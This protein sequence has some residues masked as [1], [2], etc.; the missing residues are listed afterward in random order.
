MNEIPEFWR[1]EVYHPL[2]VHF[3]IVLL[4]MA[5]LFKL[6]GL[7]SSKITWEQGGRFLLILGVIG[8]WIS[9][10][11]GDLADGI[12]SRELCD[13]TMLKD[14]ENFAFITAWIFSAALVIEL[15]ISYIDLFK[16]KM[17]SLIL[18][19]VLL[20]GSGTLAYVGHLGAELVYQQAA[21]VYVPSE[22]CTEFN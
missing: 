2:S 3:P 6:I 19:L 1:T 20:V 5:T 14:H 9:V 21:G 11:T 16:T 8:V 12:V 10:Y 7:W 22:D 13:P 15:L 17:L 18:V 4:L